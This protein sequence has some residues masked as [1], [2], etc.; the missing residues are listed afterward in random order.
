MTVVGE[1]P[2][3]GGVT[4]AYRL[5][6]RWVMLGLIWTSYFSFGVVSGSIAPLVTPILKDLNISFSQMGI[7]LGSWPLTYIAVA[8]IAGTILDRWGIHKSLFIGIL[9]VGISAAIRYFA[10]GFATMFLFVA[11]FGLG[12]PIISIGSPKTISLWFSGKD[13]ATAVGVYSTAPAVGRLVALS[14]TNSVVMPLTGYSWRLTFVVY[15]LLAFVSALTWWFL[16]RDIRSTNAE[17]GTSFVRV[18]RELVS[19]RNVQLILI[20]GFLSFAI[21]HGFTNWLPKILETSGLSPA[22]AGF[23]ASIPILVGIPAVLG[24]TPLVRQRLRGR[25]VALTALATAIALMIVATA[26]GGIIITG[27]VLAGV[28]LRVAMPLMILVLMDLREVGS[29]HMGSAGGMYFCVAEIG[30]FTGPFLVGVIKDISGSFLVGMSFLAGLA[31]AIS[32][33]ALLV[34]IQPAGDMETTK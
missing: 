17:T 26:S 7:I 8:T 27:L 31:L 1:G 19:I 33:I 24:V 29:K 14:L 5:R 12:G 23:G 3:L 16:A 6:Y 34:R 11:I 21:N 9:I 25:V 20:M 18:F 4:D 22:V 32:V 2:T 15:S 13:R 10:H 28:C 30:G